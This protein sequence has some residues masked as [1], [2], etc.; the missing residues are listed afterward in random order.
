MGLATLRN[1]REKQRVHVVG[2]VYEFGGR[3]QMPRN[4]PRDPS[5]GFPRVTF[6]WFADGKH[7]DRSVYRTSLLDFV[8]LYDFV[9]REGGSNGDEI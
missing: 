4:D 7:K 1:W 3:Y 8:E 6:P 9:T 2:Q 5:S